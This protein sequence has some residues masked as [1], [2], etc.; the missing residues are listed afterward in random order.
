MLRL[1]LDPVKDSTLIL[2]RWPFWTTS[3]TLATRPSLRSS[4]MWTNPSQRFLQWK[5]K[6]V[7]NIGFS[8]HWITVR[9]RTCWVHAIDIVLFSSLTSVPPVARSS[10][11][12]GCWWLCRW[13][14]PLQQAL[15]VGAGPCV[16]PYSGQNQ[17]Q[18]LDPWRG[19]DCD[20]SSG[21]H[22]FDRVWSLCPS[23][24]RKTE[25]V[26]VSSCLCLGSDFCFA[27]FCC[28]T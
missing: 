3:A 21:K 4:E 20:H 26:S 27:A 9:Y 13:I 15:L 1:V 8:K 22:V 19:S 28:P 25:S 7:F 18:C 17:P 23:H 10:Q 11:T 6:K 14:C 12:A 24:G 5:T 2:T 16:C